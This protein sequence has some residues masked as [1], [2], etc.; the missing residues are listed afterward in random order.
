MKCTLN[1]RRVSPL[2]NV[3]S[4]TGSWGITFSTGG[5]GAVTGA[6]VLAVASGAGDFGA[7]T[8]V[9]VLGAASGAAVLGAASGVA[10][11]GVAAGAEILGAASGRGGL[12]AA[13]RTGPWS[14]LLLH[15]APARQMHH[16]AERNNL[17]VFIV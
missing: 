11:L 7:V 16:N 17:A 14:D 1:P 15:P 12:G 6:A 2:C 13:F 5:L 10:G 4:V 9:V 8:G 3:I